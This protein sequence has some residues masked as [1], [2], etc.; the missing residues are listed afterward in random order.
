MKLLPPL[1]E[2][3]LVANVQPLP[4]LDV[5]APNAMP[6]GFERKCHAP[7]SSLASCRR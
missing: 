7:T 6:L 5:C 3:W 4:A 1:L 2:S